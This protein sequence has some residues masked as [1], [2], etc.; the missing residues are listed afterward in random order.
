MVSIGLGLVLRHAYPMAFGESPRPY[1]EYTIQRGYEVGPV[2]LP[3][4]DYVMILICVVLLVV[5]GLLL[6]RTRMGIAMRAVADERDLAEASGV[7]VRKVT[8][9]TWVSGAAAPRSVA[10]SR[11]SVTVSCGTWG[12]RCSC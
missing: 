5:V 8:L 1:G 4:K 2:S 12:S 11:E 9:V 7:D 3:P 6:Q 10:C